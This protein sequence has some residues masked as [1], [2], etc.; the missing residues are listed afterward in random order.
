MEKGGDYQLTRK[1]IRE[2]PALKASEVGTECADIG[3]Q[4]WQIPHATFHDQVT[5]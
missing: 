4:V 3:W 1:G 5:A 2:R